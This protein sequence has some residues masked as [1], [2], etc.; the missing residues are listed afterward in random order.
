MTALAPPDTRDKAFTAL[1]VAP[2]RAAF[3][4]RVTLMIVPRCKMAMNIQGPNTMGP[5]LEAR[6]SVLAELRNH[7]SATLPHKPLLS[8]PTAGTVESETL[9]GRR[10][11]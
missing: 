3:T 5:R 6:I 1:A 11:T 2:C 4:T 8:D 7:R 9:Q 10:Q